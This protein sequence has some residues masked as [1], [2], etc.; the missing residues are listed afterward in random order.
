MT[1]SL[2]P[3]SPSGFSDD[4]CDVYGATGGSITLQLEHKLTSSQVLKWTHDNVVIFERN[5][6]SLVIGK[7]NDI[8]PNGSLWLQ[9]LTNLTAGKYKPEI[10]DDGQGKGNLKAISLC[11][12]GR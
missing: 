7:N 3:P 11:V 10:F 5:S 12:L 9:K 8:H 6:D 4:T 1:L 2:F